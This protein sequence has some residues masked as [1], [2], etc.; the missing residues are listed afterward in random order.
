M[1]AEKVRPYLIG[2]TGNIATGK[3]SIIRILESYGAEVIDADLITHDLLRTDAG[4]QRQL[5]QTFGEPILLSDGQGVDR[6]KLGAIVFSDPEKLKILEQLLHPV[7]I[8][9]IHRIL[10][11]TTSDVVVLEA[12]KLIESGLS[13]QCDTVWVVTASREVQFERLVNYR[14]LSQHE[15]WQRID[16]QPPQEDKIQAA[17]IL[18]NNDGSLASLELQVWWAFRQSMSAR[19]SAPA[20]ADPG[21][22][23]S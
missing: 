20:A 16:A 18:I 6:R 8:D 21:A 13:E 4:I 12:I 10:N 23:I 11:D 3:S 19:G 9:R 14:G 5:A 15:A 17:D 2:L 1:S 22:T 7:I